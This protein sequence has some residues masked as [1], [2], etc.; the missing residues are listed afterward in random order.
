MIFF[1]GGDKSEFV[2]KM[3]DAPKAAK[4]KRRAD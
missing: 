1:R 4:R 3:A 2:A